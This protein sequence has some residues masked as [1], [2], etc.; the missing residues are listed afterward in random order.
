MAMAIA[1][2]TLFTFAA[3]AA[4]FTPSIER[5]DAPELIDGPEGLVITP[6]SDIYDED[7][8]LHEDIEKSL[9]DAEDELKEK[10]LEEL[11]EEFEKVWE[12]ATKGAPTEHA[13]ISDIF[14]VRFTDELGNGDEDD[15]EISFKVK[16]LGIEAEDLFILLAKNDEDA[17][18][19]VLEYELSDDGIITIKTT[20]QS[21]LAVVKDNE[22]PPAINPDDPD[23]PQTGVG[24]HFIP[25]I[26]GVVVFAS[27]AGACAVKAAKGKTE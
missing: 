10:T 4:S 23:S 3:T 2:A 20:T 7:V 11:V 25:A 24:T 14:D 21:V 1:L 27:L 5:K 16:E 12:D 18:W 9:T 19:L 15:I 8:D 26:V 6:I 13:I 22:A 17:P